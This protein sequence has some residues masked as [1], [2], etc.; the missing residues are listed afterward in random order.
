[1]QS[2]FQAEFHHRG[3]NSIKADGTGGNAMEVKYHELDC[4][5]NDDYPVKCRREGNEVFMPFTFIQQYFEVLTTSK[6]QIPCSLI[7]LL[8]CLF[9]VVTVMFH[10]RYFL[11]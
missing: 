11:N 5:I 3:T 7:A 8:Q 4:Y 2:E 6:R 9:K 1:M 10:Q